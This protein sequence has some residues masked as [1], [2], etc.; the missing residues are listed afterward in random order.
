MHTPS[1]EWISTFRTTATESSDPEVGRKAR[2][3]DKLKLEQRL[4][5]SAAQ[6]PVQLPTEASSKLT[7]S[8]SDKLSAL[9]G[10][11]IHTTDKITSTR[12]TKF[13]LA[14][15]RGKAGIGVV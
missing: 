13:C 5:D 6:L 9:P 4:N 1:L 3:L 7:S 11:L 2:G 12:P 15:L 10:A 14:T 8:E